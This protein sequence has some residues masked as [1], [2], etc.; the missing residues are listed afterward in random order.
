MTGR[1]IENV[2]VSW[3]WK[4]GTAPVARRDE[5]SQPVG[6]ANT[7]VTLT[8]RPVTWDF[9]RGSPE[10]WLGIFGFLLKQRRAAPWSI[11]A[12][13]EGSIS[14]PPRQVSLFVVAKVSRRTA[15]ALRARLTWNPGG[16]LG[17]ATSLRFHR[18]V[19]SYK[20]DI[21]PVSAGAYKRV[22]S[23]NQ[24]ERSSAAGRLS[25]RSRVG[26]KSLDASLNMRLAFE[27]GAN[28]YAV[29]GSIA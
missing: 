27:S 8:G 1:H 22:A 7:V 23:V 15:Q 25:G 28:P 19:T 24:V 29:P 12:R 17:G 13:V 21:F 4:R 9:Q 2:Q 5:G 3:L 18:G 26:I 14:S 11:S 6:T 10:T 16:G 20:F